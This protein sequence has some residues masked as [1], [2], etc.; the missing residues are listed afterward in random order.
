MLDVVMM[1]ASEGDCLILRYG[2]ASA[3]RQVL[4]DAGRKR[5]Y[6]LLCEFLPKDQRRFELFVVSHVDR[7]HIEG[8]LDV[9]G[10]EEAGFSF[11][12]IWFNAYRHLD[13]IPDSEDFGAVQGEKLTATIERRGLPWNRA[14]DGGPVRIE[15]QP[16]VMQLEGGLQLTLLSPDA[17]KLLSLKPR[18]EAE[19]RRAGLDPSVPSP[20]EE[21]ASED[22]DAQSPY[23]TFG[24]ETLEELAAANTPEDSAAPNGSSIAFLAEFGGKAILFGAD[25]HPRLLAE[26]LR[27]LG[28]PLPIACALVKVPHHGSQANTTTELL[29]CIRASDFLIST[30]GS[31]FEHPD[32]VAIA[33]LLTAPTPRPRTLHFNYD[34]PR[35]RAWDDDSLMQDYGYRCVFPNAKDKPLTVTL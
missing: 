21:S 20:D 30:N 31:Y 13:W 34:Q 9:L 19:C 27:A 18:W 2:D 22:P 28:R 26:S 15:G 32:E 3:P 8:A 5:T 33:R 12:D 11:G 14:F 35:T 16:R 17:S 25:A 6:R 10:D 29:G 24:D 7:D 1:P 4:I 23:E